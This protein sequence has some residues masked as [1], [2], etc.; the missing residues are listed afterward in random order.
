MEMGIQCILRYEANHPEQLK[1]AY[2][3]NGNLQENK[4]ITKNPVK[5]VTGIS[6][7]L[8]NDSLVKIDINLDGN[9][10]EI[11]PIILLA[12]AIEIP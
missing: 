9:V 6:L 2:F 4:F 1:K 10:M 12:N 3:L 11:H 7:C 5:N 8:F